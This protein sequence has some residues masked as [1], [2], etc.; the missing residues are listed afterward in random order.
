[1]NSISIKIEHDNDGNLV[2][3]SGSVDAMA[4]LAPG[5]YE[6]RRLG[7]DAKTLEGKYV[8]QSTESVRFMYRGGGPVFVS[9]EPAGGYSNLDPPPEGVRVTAHLLLPDPPPM[10]L[11]DYPLPPSFMFTVE[12]AV[13]APKVG[14]TVSVHVSWEVG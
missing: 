7:R 14:E 13:L 10:W 11:A 1:M 8:V 6:M 2:I 4:G 3:P 12:D 5:T 9:K